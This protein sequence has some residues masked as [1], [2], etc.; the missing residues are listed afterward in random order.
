MTQR[1][2]HIFAAC[3]FGSLL[4]PC[5]A[6]AQTQ[7]GAPASPYGGTTVEQ[8]IARVNDQ[9]ITSA[10]YDRAQTELE[11]EARQHDESMQQVSAE[12]KDL[13]RS[14]IDQ[15]LWLSK[16]KEVGITGETDLVK[17]LDEIR[18]QY[19]LDSI[20]DL[21]KAAKE[22]GVSFDDFKQNI[23]NQI[24]TQEV[25]RQEVGE[26]I[27][28]TPG[29]AEQYYNLHKQ[30]FSQPESERLSEI[31]ISANTDDAAKLAEAKAKADDLEAR[32][33][34]GGDF[35][36]LARHFSEGPTA[37][38]G[39]D[40]GQY[41]LGQLPKLLEDK[42]FSLSTGQY[43]DPI[44]TRQGYI[45]LKVTQH[46]AGGP[47]A[48]KDVQ[49]QVEE[50]LYMSRMEPAIRDYLTKMREDAFIDIAPGYVDTGASPNETKPVYSAY[51]PPAPKKKAKVERTRFRE[52]THTFRQK[53]PASAPSSA[54]DTSEAPQPDQLQP[55]PAQPNQ[56]DNQPQPNPAQPSQA[57]PTQAQPNQ[58]PAK[59]S[60]AD[61]KKQQQGEK[62][63]KKEKIRFGQAPRETLPSAA[64]NASTE[65]A[66]ALPENSTAGASNGG[67]A[68]SADN[69]QQPV[70]PLEPT[71]PDRKTRFSSR[72]HEQ[73]KKKP[74]F[75]HD[76]LAPVAPNAGEV[77]DQ[78]TQSAPLGLNGNTA[79]KK[80]KKQQSTT[81][82][83]TR[84]SEEKKTPDNTTPQAAP[85]PTPIAPVPGAP[86]P[87]QQPQAQPQ[88]QAPAQPE[89]QPQPQQ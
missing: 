85:Q 10:D 42:T 55:N 56:A 46:V 29:E 52:S 83:K 34:A 22:Q 68:E 35:T 4:Y 30:D 19:N 11:A 64:N 1:I 60:K 44:L 2:L 58:A 80:K 72:A 16:G 33:H 77:A 28:F 9:I 89:A 43:T 48:Y 3:A 53:G 32:L 27:Q 86:A 88:P 54:P 5:A 31:L 23:R 59:L 73:R 63:G 70:N 76:A 40:L 7:G 69:T 8:I 38:A 82:E 25:M 20:E 61:R 67:G 41:K 51:V 65:N 15:Q 24:I 71:A 62:P 49:E 78:Q 21:E 75:P 87:Q 45:V 36:D 79:S 26:H 74:A 66:G 37:S 18:K 47:A 39:G 13:L 81:G 6:L 84:Y 14:L 17:R 50:A 57:Q 12:R